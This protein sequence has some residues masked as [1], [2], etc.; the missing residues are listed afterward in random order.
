MTDIEYPYDESTGRCCHSV[1][2]S[3]TAGQIAELITVGSVPFP[4]ALLMM[5]LIV[6][7]SLYLVLGFVVRDVN[8]VLADPIFILN[9]KDVLNAELQYQ[10]RPILVIKTDE[11]SA[12]RVISKVVKRFRST[13]NSNFW[14]FFG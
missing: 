14:P 12:I 8:L 9:L 7:G 3:A 13:R 10:L 4:V 11:T 1:P 6:A 2:P 5:F